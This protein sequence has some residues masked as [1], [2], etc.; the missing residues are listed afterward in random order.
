MVDLLSVGEANLWHVGWCPAY[1]LWNFVQRSIQ[2][3]YR[4]HLSDQSWHDL[5]DQINYLMHFL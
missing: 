3:A 5:K 1:K 2:A 4:L